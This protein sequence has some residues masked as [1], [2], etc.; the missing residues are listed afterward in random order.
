MESKPAPLAVCLAVVSVFIAQHGRVRGQLSPPVCQTWNSTTVVCKWDDDLYH[1]ITHAPL[2]QVP[3]GIPESVITVDLSENNITILY[4]GS[5]SGLRNLRSLDLSD[6]PIQTIEAGA[7][8]RLEKLQRLDIYDSQPMYLLHNGMF[9]DLRN[10]NYLAVET[11]TDTVAS[12][13]VF[14]GLSKLRHLRLVMN[15]S[16]LPDHI[17]DPLTSLESLEIVGDYIEDDLVHSGSGFLQRRLLWAPLNNLKTL[18]LEI[19]DF[20]LPSASDFYFGPVFTNMSRLET[21]EIY[22]TD[23]SLNAQ[24]FRPLLPTVKHLR[25]GARISPGLLKS[26]THL[27]TLDFDNRASYPYFTILDVLPELRHTQI[28]ELS[29]FNMELETQ[30]LS[31][32]TL[33][34]I[35]GLKSLKTLIFKS[36]SDLVTIEANAFAGLSHLHRLDLTR[37]TLETLHDKAFSGLSSVTHLNLTQSWISTLPQYVFEG[38]SSL[39]HL[40]LSQNELQTSQ[41]QLPETL[42]Y[43]DL[44]H[45]KL[46]GVT[47]QPCNSSISFNFGSLKWVNHLNLSHNEIDLVPM[48]C[49]PRNIT[50]LD[51]Q[52]NRLERFLALCNIEGLRYLD[53]SNNE[54][55]DFFEFYS[56]FTICWQPGI[57]TLKLDNNGIT[58]IGEGLPAIRRSLK[59]LTLSHNQIHRIETGQLTWSDQLEH[60]D[61]SHNEINTVMPSAFRGLSRLQFLDLSNNKIKNITKTTFEGLG[62]LTHLNLEAN[63]IP[64]I[65]DAFKRLYGLRHLNLRSNS[66]AVLNQTTLGPVVHRLETIDIADNP[67]LCDCN[68]MWFVEWALDK[69]DRVA[70]FHNPYPDF[71]RGYTCSRPAGLRGRRLIDGLTQKQKSNDRQDPSERKFFDTVCSHGFRPNRLLACVLASSGI[72]VAMTTIFLVDYHVGR[73]Q[74]LLWMLDKWRRPKIGEVKNQEP[75]RYTHDAFLAYNNRDVWWVIHQAIENLEPDYSLVIHERDFAVGAPIVEN[76][77]DAVEN[78]RRT[79]CLITRN[80]LKSKWCEYE[81]QLAQY[82]MFEEGGGVRLILVFLE[83]IPNEMLKQFNHLNA[84]V[85]RDTYLTWPDD[86]RKR[87]LFWRRLRDALGDPLP[88]DPEPQQQAQGPEQNAPERNIPEEQARVLERNIPEQQEQAP[89]RDI[90]ETDMESKPAP[91][92]VCL[93]VVSVFIAQHGRVRGQLPPP[94]CQTWNS[95]TVV[96]KG[97]GLY[98]PTRAPLTQVP[99]GIPESVIIMDLSKNNITILYN[100]SFKIHRIETGQLTRSDQLEHL[101]LSHNEINTVMPSAFRGLSRLQFLDLSNNKIKN[102]TKSTFEGLGNLAHLNL[103]ANRIA[104]IGGAFQRLYGLRHLNLRSNSLAVLN[105]TTLGPVVSWLE[106]IDIADNPFLCDCNL[107][108]F[109]E[110]ALDKYDRVAN[111]HNPYPDVGRG[112]T[113]S[114]PAGLRGRRLIDGLTQI[115][116]SNNRQDPSERKFFDIVCSHGFR[117]NRLLACVLA[118]SGI[119][120]AMTTIFLVDY[121]VGRVQYYLWMLDKWRRP[122][123]G[124]VKNKEPHR[125]THDAFLAYNNRDVGWVIHQA[126]EN[127]EP[128]YS[129]VIHERDFAVGAPIV[130]NIADAVENS[131][132]T[133]CLITRNFLKSKWCE[134]EFQL[135]QYHMFEEGGGVRLILVFLERIP[136]EML[137]Q[138]RHLNAVVKRDTYLMWPDDV[139][140]RPLFWRRLRD[141]LGD[142]LP[143]DP[144]PQQQVQGPEQNAP[145]RN[146]PE[147]PVRNIPEDPVR[148]IPEDPVRNIPEQQELAQIRN[149]VEVQVHAPM[150]DIPELQ[151]EI[152][153]PDPD[154]QWFG[155]GDDVPLLPL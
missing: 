77:A 91:L 18:R 136:N 122:K 56:D 81:F 151:D 75:H 26:L 52:H 145:E 13:G 53:L 4:N 49:F 14:T 98:H 3:P 121:H 24:M 74:Y 12:E 116:H 114:R 63:R 112:Y 2:T 152:L 28:Q 42:D 94:V 118:S 9:Q 126:I 43:L 47:G 148:N 125:Y 119:F 86:V 95:T 23:V 8:A 129:L 110:C 66:L 27:Q 149:V 20:R 128:D 135:A 46:Y 139:R 41:A 68:S 83:R 130:E 30:K 15:I 34:G 100:G 73:V 97:D 106:T 16:N 124:E 117:P 146:I 5:F 104:V 21:I 137:K 60:L 51:L 138:F 141:A 6:N 64:V 80:F 44:S 111:F 127:L 144:E 82:H 48:T 1:P 57:E 109:A 70:N 25:T 76:I 35:K 120:V 105:Q 32:D 87:P 22:Q 58:E 107:M 54:L 10:L 102:I 150:R 84:V 33:A 143:R 154:D 90:V 113:C 103:E 89:V 31:S 153:L 29:F 123:I 45:N 134:Y 155:D 93:A 115:Q 36:D 88:R 142:P 39:T 108:W 79:V 50:V 55:D 140:K 38:L 19:I 78:S 11:Y 67:F 101:D 96:C 85:K 99:P 69:Y 37:V 17:F 72:F 92:A 61:L 131:R 59:T 7:F 62:N 71:G 132:R 133:V 65:G 40:D 147:D